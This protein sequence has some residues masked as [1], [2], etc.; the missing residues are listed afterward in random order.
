MSKGAKNNHYHYAEKY[1]RKTRY[2]RTRRHIHIPHKAVFLS[3]LILVAVGLVSTTFAAN[4]SGEL[5]NSSY[6][7]SMVVKSAR[8]VKAGQDLTPIGASFAVADTGAYTG[9][10]RVY[11]KLKDGISWAN[12]ANI[13]V[14]YQM[15]STWTYGLVSSSTTSVTVG[16]ETLSLYYAD[17]PSGSIN[18]Y[19]WV[20]LDST[21]DNNV[22]NTSIGA[23]S[24][25]TNNSL[26]YS[27][28]NYTELTGWDSSNRGVIMFTGDTFYLDSTD[29]I[30]WDDDVIAEDRVPSFSNV[31]VDANPKWLGQSAVR[32]ADGLYKYEL[33]DN[34]VKSDSTNLYW[35]RG[36]CLNGNDSYW[37]VSNAMNA[38][39]AYFN[40]KNAMYMGNTSAYDNC[41]TQTTIALTGLT[42][43]TLSATTNS[44]VRTTSNTI[45]VSNAAAIKLL[46]TR[47]GV[48]DSTDLISGDLTYT[49]YDNG[50][51]LYSGASSTYDA[52]GFAAGVHNVTVK[53]ESALTGMSATSSAY[54]I[55]VS[56][57]SY[58]VT[59]VENGASNGTVTFGSTAIS[60]APGTSVNE[61]TYTITIVA[62]T[63][64]N[65]SSV[66][67][68]SGAW[69]IEGD[70][71]TLTGYELGSN[72]TLTIDYVS[73]YVPQ[74]SLTTSSATADLGD[75]VALTL[76]KSNTDVDPTSFTVTKDGAAATVNTHYTISGSG[77][78][79]TFTPK[80]AGEFEITPV[81]AGVSVTSGCTVTAYA[82]T[83]SVPD[84]S[85]V[86]IGSS[87]TPVP[88]FTYP[89]SISGTVT[90]TLSSGSS[91]S[92]TNSVI[93]AV[94]AGTSTVLA[95]YH[96]TNNGFS[97][98]VTT[99]FDVTVVNPTISVDNVTGATI[100]STV[101]PLPSYG[102]PAELRGSVSYSIYSGNSVSIQDNVITAVRPGNTVVTA[103]YNYL[104]NSESTTVTNTFTITVNTPTLSLAS[105]TLVVEEKKTET[106]QA[107]ASPAPHHY[108]WAESS[109]T[110][111]VISL[112]NTSSNTVSV[113][114]DMITSASETATITVKAVYASG[115]ETTITEAQ[116]CTVTVRASYY[117]IVGFGSGNW[118]TNNQAR[119]LR[120]D[121]ESQNGSYTATINLTKGSYSSG[122]GDTGFKIFNSNTNEY[123]TDQYTNT[124]TR[125]N[126][127]GWYFTT[128][129]GNS[130]NTGLT[131]DVTG[132]YIFQFFPSTNILNVVYPDYVTVTFD[133]TQLGGSSTVEKVRKDATMT[134][135]NAV[136]PTNPIKTG[137]SFLGWTK[138][139][140]AHLLTRAEVMAEE[141]SSNVTYVA[142]Y[143]LDAP[144][145][146]FTNVPNNYAVGG[147]AANLVTSWTSSASDLTV[148]YSFSV[149][150]VTTATGGETADGLYD[151]DSDPYFTITPSDAT[152]AAFSAEIPGK[153][154]VTYSVTISDGAAKGNHS[155]TASVSTYIGAKPAKPVISFTVT[156]KTYNEYTG[157]DPSLHAPGSAENP[158]YLALGVTSGYEAEVTS[159]HEGTA[160]YTYQWYVYS[161]NN[162]YSSISPE[163]ISS[164]IDNNRKITFDVSTITETTSGNIGLVVACI[165]SCNGYTSDLSNTSTTYYKIDSWI[166]SFDFSVIQKIYAPESGVD[167]SA[168]YNVIMDSD[169]YPTEGFTTSVKASNNSSDKNSGSWSVFETANGA[170]A[171]LTAFG[172]SLSFLASSGVKYLYLNTSVYDNALHENLE[173]DDSSSVIH[174]TVGTSQANAAK[175]F[176]FK[177]TDGSV[178]LLEYRVMAFWIEDDN[179]KYQ[180]MQ[181]VGSMYRAYLPADTTAVSIVAAK[182]GYHGMP[183]SGITAFNSDYFSYVAQNISL[184]TASTEFAQ[185]YNL[186]TVT[187]KGEES[188]QVSG[189]YPSMVGALSKLG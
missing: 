142:W 141:Y 178:D 53:V 167:L 77:T 81:N 94:S 39:E 50:V 10:K 189:F 1:E 165:A 82:P 4:F 144:T 36:G 157:I 54:T 9:Q 18:G 177:C 122:S 126:S 107:T 140:G 74:Y 63:D 19:R 78:S 158:Y 162:M 121:S 83:I 156:G 49:F 127:T 138:D 95:T 111:N 139:S 135:S 86:V 115:Y 35:Y 24:L 143:E 152:H 100:D 76:T 181:T 12:G 163:R 108:V 173:R 34:W 73:I 136:A 8:A 176:Y 148:E 133:D 69:D 5:S 7:P 187:S 25:S 186:Y 183:E 120:F 31:A 151:E 119:R 185:G 154:T 125:S 60:A 93:K 51:E 150:S 159:T 98:S 55:T 58:T 47:G 123:R 92:V 26:D 116:T 129:G 48:A 41:G 71:A 65:V 30:R 117:Y 46:Y 102:N 66:S 110:A 168:V 134:A 109:D 85:D 128:I 106:L 132:D 114:A 101:A 104:Y 79:Y 112:S 6:T 21:N 72:A 84:I 57:I 23:K 62:P 174:T 175:P 164:T 96:Y 113:T 182:K 68:V 38:G 180:T 13:K 56:P 29:N 14:E 137:Y 15:N 153:Y 90:Y 27:A 40:G 160:T 166:T 2:T 147:S 171:K 179:V 88:T 105:S 32:I 87:P 33:S 20:R 149:D 89:T 59:K 97:T 22:Y 124:M 118:A 42:T 188:E 161:G 103:T 170:S 3:L 146:S 131:A 44:P 64:Y 80:T 43:P 169:D 45:S 28:Y 130:N 61:G 91:V 16:D 52:S 75:N 67:G 99:T 145:L 155:A 70:T 184:N 37:N 17:L 11:L 172:P